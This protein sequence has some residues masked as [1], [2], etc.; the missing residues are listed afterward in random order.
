MQ[1]ESLRSAVNFAGFTIDPFP[2]RCPSPTPWH[3]SHVIPACANGSP[4]YSFLVPGSLFCNPL[5]WQFRQLEN[6]GK[7]MGISRASAYAG[8]ISH[9]PSCAYQLIGV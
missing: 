7:F 9:F 8:V 1:I 5:V 2:S 3:R 6:E 4:A